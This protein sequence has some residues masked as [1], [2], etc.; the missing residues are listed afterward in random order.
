MRDH[1]SNVSREIEFSRISPTGVRAV[2]EAHGEILTVPAEKGSFRNITNTPGTMERQ[3]AW[4]PHGRSIAYFSDESGL[5]AL[6][7][8]GQDGIGPVKKFKLENTATYYFEPRWSPDS[9]LIAFSDNKLNIWYLN[10]GFGQA[11]KDR[12]GLQLDKSFRRGVVAGFEMARLYAH[13]S[14]PAARSVSVFG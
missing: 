4:S 8:A 6:H 7:I 3:P 9:K 2:F 13:A 14:E 1:L 11:R 5:Y 12:H 10:I